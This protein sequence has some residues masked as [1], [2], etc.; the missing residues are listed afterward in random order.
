MKLIFIHGPAAAGKL[1]VARE[2]SQ[3]T[4]LGVF[5]N[6]LV[7]DALLAVFSF[8]SKP[9]VELREKMW[10]DVF[11]EATQTKT[12]LIFT[13]A[14]DITVQPD[15]ISKTISTIENYGGE[16]IFVKLTCADAESEKRVGSESRKEFRKLR[17]VETMRKSRAAGR[18][19]FPPLPDSGLTIDTT[20]T[21]PSESARLIQEFLDRRK[22]PNPKQPSTTLQNE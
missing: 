22:N 3:R 5:H 13:F 9:F 7:V 12:S 14:P 1:T 8:G 10:P 16:V 17:S 15:F 6:H 2:L 4:G 19:D 20:H 21:M 18:D 11:R